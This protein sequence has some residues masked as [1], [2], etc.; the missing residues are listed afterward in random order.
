MTRWRLLGG[1][2]ACAVAITGLGLRPA[3]RTYTIDSS[4][5]RATIEVGKSGAFS[6]AAGHTHEVAV[7]AIAG[8]MTWTARIP[9]ARAST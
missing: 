8:T 7:S 6:F 2:L 3:A 5:S 9:A 4:R 1:G